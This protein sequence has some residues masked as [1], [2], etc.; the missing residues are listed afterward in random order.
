MLHPKSRWIT[1]KKNNDNAAIL[2]DQLKITPLVASLLVNR[3]YDSLEKA[4]AFLY[5]IDEF[6]DP[7]LMKGMDIAVN[8][9]KHAIDKQEPILIFG[10]YDADGVTST[11]VMMKT[12]E[13]LGADVQFYIPNR[14]TEGYGPNEG[15]FRYAASIG[16]KLIVTVDTGIAAVKEADVAKELGI[17]YIVTDHHEPGLVLPDALAIIHPRLDGSEYPFHELAGVGVALKVAHALYGE[18]PEHLLQFAAIGTIADLVS[19]TGENRIIAKLGIKKLKQTANI[20][21]QALLKQMKTEASGIDEETIGFMIAPRINAVGRLDSADPAVELLLTDDPDLAASLAEEMEAINKERQAIVNQI[22]EEAIEQVET[23]Y[24]LAENRVIIVGKEGWNPGVVGIVASRLVEKFYR[25]T[26]VLG[27]DQEKGIAKGSARSIAGF[28][29]Y[30]NLSTCREILPHFGGH[31]MA[32]GMTLALEDVDQLRQRLNQLAFDKLV[33]E[34]LVPLTAVDMEIDLKD[35][36]LQAI[37]EMQLLA[38]FGV[39][40]AKPRIVM[41]SVEIS[42]IR[43][44]GANQNHLKVQFQQ[45]DTSLDGI[46]FGIGELYDHISPSAKVSVLGQLSINEWN[47][48]KKPQIFIQDIAVKHWQLFDY[49][50][51]RNLEKL[52]SA[53]PGNSA[54][55][56]FFHKD[57]ATPEALNSISDYKIIE[58]LDDAASFQTEN[59]I[60]VLADFPHSKDIVQ[61]LLA[62]TAPERIYAS[63]FK[64][65]SDFFSTMPTRDHFKW[66]YAFLAKQ[67]GFDLKK[68][69]GELAKRQGWSKETIVFMSKVFFELNFVTMKDGFITLNKNSNRRDLTES[70]SFQQKQAQFSLENELIYSS[71]EQLKNWFDLILQKSV[72]NE[73]EVQEWI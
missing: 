50:G 39:D 27:F 44:I 73:E 29:L 64:Q 46:G 51:I 9:I 70:P 28:D 57:S 25:P 59:R 40:N 13:D 54:T 8:R 35:A 14:F 2:A 72:K 48:I 53:I 32:A 37:E 12:L 15:A 19:L 66:Y 71:Y 63:F 23:L 45:E 43:K 58:N 42:T 22:T 3:G 11:T 17:D 36:H 31:P 16:I 61:Q 55:W 34:D 49:R 47:N 26:I 41:D 67:N 30:Q 6:H 20:G 4:K 21:L 56:I 5:S 18:L 65:D 52:A 69:G 24:P 10:D 1:E 38:P 33:P 62:S 7:F 68:Y 60:L